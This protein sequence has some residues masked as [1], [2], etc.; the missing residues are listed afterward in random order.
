MVLQIWWP[1]SSATFASCPQCYSFVKPHPAPY[2]TTSSVAPSTA[3][4]LVSER[5]FLTP[6]G[7]PAENED[8]IQ[9]LHWVAAPNPSRRITAAR[10]DTPESGHFCLCVALF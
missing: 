5:P 6:P 7:S 9:K 10:V 1:M 4:V 3:C 8:G 2:P